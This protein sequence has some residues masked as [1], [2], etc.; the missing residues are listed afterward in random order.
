[1]AVTVA[2]NPRIAPSFQQGMMGRAPQAPVPV[3]MSPQLRA[4]RSAPVA[5]GYNG[6]DQTRSV[7]MQA[8]M[9]QYKEAGDPFNA[10]AQGWV[11]S[12]VQREANDVAI[13]K[14]EEIAKS[15]E[16]HPDLQKYI[17][18]GV[19]G[20]EDAIRIKETREAATKETEAAAAR[21]AEIGQYLGELAATDS[22][23]AKLAE[24]WA[25]GVLD[26]DALSKA[27]TEQDK[28]TERKYEKD[29]AGVQR[30]IDTGEPV[31][32]DEV[33]GEAPPDVKGESALRTELSGLNTTKDFGLQTGAYQRVLSSAKDPSPAG[34]LALI[35]N[36]MK[37]LDPGSTVREGEFATAQNS[38][39]VPEQIW[40]M[41]NKTVSGERLVPE[42]RADFVKRA[43]EL[44][45]GAAG[46]QEGTNSRYSELATDYGYEPERIVAPIPKIGVLDPAFNLDEYLNP[47]GTQAKPLPVTNDAEFDAL[48]S[49]A[50]FIDP[51]GNER[52]KP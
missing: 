13:A 16:G 36:F 11:N 46:L 52:I 27:I 37:V 43:G 15:F 32:K 41:Y 19:M 5:P 14:R 31:F 49:G 50:R 7:P 26:E 38:G 22:K 44:Y 51:E 1:M 48:P 35:F 21:K 45:Q 4:A 42:I 25:A 34:D 12:S 28:P 20:P 17:Q 10:F 24:G 40:A 8:A 9:E 3:A 29:A 30:Y 23:Y 33:G 47:D 6:S 18:T 39:S 2:P